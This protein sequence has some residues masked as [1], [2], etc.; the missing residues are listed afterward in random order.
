MI[1][2]LDEF[3]LLRLDSRVLHTVR[4][5]GLVVLRRMRLRLIVAGPTL[6][7]LLVHCVVQLSM[8][9]FILVFDVALIGGSTLAVKYLYFL[10]GFMA[11]RPI[12]NYGKYLQS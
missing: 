4:N 8:I 12:N 10:G 7:L 1:R 3:S 2:C 5:K 6:G 11:V 9:L